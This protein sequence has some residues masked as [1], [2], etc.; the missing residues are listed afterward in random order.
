MLERAVFSYGE[1]EIVKKW[2]KNKMDMKVYPC[3]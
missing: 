1:L 3:G 2:G